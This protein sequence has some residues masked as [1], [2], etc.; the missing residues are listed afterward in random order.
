MNLCAFLTHTWCDIV[1]DNLLEGQQLVIGVGFKNAQM[2]V[3]ITRGHCDDLVPLKSDHEEANTRLLL[4]VKHACHEHNRIVIQSPDTEAAVLCTT[5]YTNLQ[6]WVLRFRTGVQDKARYI[7]IHNLSCAMLYWAFT[8]SD[9]RGKG[10]H[11]LTW[12]QRASD[13]SGATHDAK[14]LGL[15]MEEST[16]T[17]TESATSSWT[18]QESSGWCPA[19]C[20]HNQRSS[21]TGSFGAECLSLQEVNMSPSRPHL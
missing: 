10:S 11:C 14:L 2:L 6:C 19:A 21:T 16:G 3:L 9:R 4:H 12:Q 17:Y 18:W 13:Q 1:V 5:H 15:C 20:A 7:P 8:Y